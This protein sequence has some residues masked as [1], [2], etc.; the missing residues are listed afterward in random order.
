M[1]TCKKLVE[2]VTDY[3]E[4]ALSPADRDLFE[5]HLAGCD[6]CDRYLKQ[7]RLTIQLLGRLTED[8][9]APDARDRLLEVFRD[10]K[11]QSAGSPG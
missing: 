7:M 10:W 8:A 9:I 11:G 4:G 3:L 5:A 2:L 6:G 1:L